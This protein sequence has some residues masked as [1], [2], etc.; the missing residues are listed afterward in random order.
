MLDPRA[1]R[2]H[3]EERWKRA[4]A[5]VLAG[6]LAERLREARHATAQAVERRGIVRI[7]TWQPRR[8]RYRILIPLAA[9]F[10][11][12]LLGTLVIGPCVSG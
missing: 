9:S 7:L 5:D 6:R 10:L 1:E 11:G 8:A 12:V 3:H 2:Q 4:R